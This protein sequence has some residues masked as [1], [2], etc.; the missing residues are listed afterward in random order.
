MLAAVDLLTVKKTGFQ[1][2]FMRILDDNI[3]TKL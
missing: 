2:N 1:V 3:L